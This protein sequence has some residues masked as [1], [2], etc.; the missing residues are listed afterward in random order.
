[1]LETNGFKIARAVER[2][3]LDL[4]I[5][6]KQFFKEAKKN[7]YNLTFKQDKFAQSFLSI[8]NNPSYYYLIATKD[9]E[10][11]GFFL[12]GI[13]S[14]LFSD[15]VLAVEMFWWVTEEFRGQNVAI[16]MLKMFEAWAKQSGATQVNVSD[17]QNVKNLDNLYKRLGYIRSE[18]TYR[19]DIP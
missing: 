13:I 18:V 11:V 10:A 8:V 4:S 2:D 6:S 9:G 5:L 7:G 15:D 14:P 1:M 3:I 17:L 12:G 16:P 19:K